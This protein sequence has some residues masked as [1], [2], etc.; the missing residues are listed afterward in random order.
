MYPG[1]EGH[2]TWTV[3]AT[4]TTGRSA[5]P[6]PCGILPEGLEDSAEGRCLHSDSVRYLRF[7]KKSLSAKTEI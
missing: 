3:A 4:E 1:S 7:L 2:Q 5:E 6:S